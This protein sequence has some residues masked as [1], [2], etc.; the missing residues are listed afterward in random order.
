MTCSGKPP[1]ITAYGVP[2]YLCA[3]GSSRAAA[4]VRELV[5][6]SAHPLPAVVDVAEQLG[7]REDPVGE[8]VRVVVERRRRSP[9]LEL[10]GQV[11]VEDGQR[12]IGE[13]PRGRSVQPAVRCRRRRGLVRPEVG[14][15]Q[16]GGTIG[17]RRLQQPQC[18]LEVGGH[19]QHERVR[20]AVVIAHAAR[21]TGGRRFATS[22]RCRRASPRRAAWPT[23]SL[24]GG[25]AGWDVPTGRSSRRSRLPS[26]R[27]PRRSRRPSREPVRRA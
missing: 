18:L 25:R 7:L 2:W 19:A 13:E 6:R 1:T 9:R 22:S 12:V 15:P 23:R 10:A 24:P 16:L 8:R 26:G 5:E 20:H 21:P 4:S 17:Q 14:G 11:V 27:E 3:A